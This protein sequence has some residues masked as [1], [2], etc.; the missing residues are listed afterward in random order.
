MG[1]PI[2]LE[3]VIIEIVD[4]W[5]TNLLQFFTLQVFHQYYMYYIH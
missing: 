3:N 1:L 2:A 5:D 4:D